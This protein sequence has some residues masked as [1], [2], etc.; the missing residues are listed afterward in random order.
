MKPSTLNRE[1]TRREVE[2]DRCDVEA[3]FV[4]HQSALEEARNAGDW[5]ALQ[6]AMAAFAGKAAAEG[7]TRGRTI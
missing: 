1:R 7:K 3:F 4:E 6:L 2:T 5:D